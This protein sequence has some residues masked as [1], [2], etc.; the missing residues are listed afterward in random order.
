MLPVT[1]NGTTYSIANG[2]IDIAGS[3]EN[4]TYDEANL[5]LATAISAVKSSTHQVNI[6]AGNNRIRGI[7]SNN[8]RTYDGVA[9]STADLIQMINV[10]QGEYTIDTPSGDS[11]VTFTSAANAITGFRVF[12]N[13]SQTDYTVSTS[14]TGNS[15]TI[16]TDSITAR[17]DDPQG[18]THT[19]TI[20]SSKNLSIQ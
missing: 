5:S 20:D 8:V 19:L 1:I 17:V 6:Q 11:I 7:T 3:D 4:L 16:G 13:S 15:V 14:S 9:D 10:G 2:N 12:A 18:N